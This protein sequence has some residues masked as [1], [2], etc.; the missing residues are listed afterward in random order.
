[1][2]SFFDFARGKEFNPL[3][4]ITGFFFNPYNLSGAILAGLESKVKA[5]G[6]F[7]EEYNFYKGMPVIHFPICVLFTKCMITWKDERSGIIHQN[8][9]KYYFQIHDNSTIMITTV[10]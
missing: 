2:N 7:V 1:M 6:D 3:K 8:G 4:N 5:Y 9:L 10:C